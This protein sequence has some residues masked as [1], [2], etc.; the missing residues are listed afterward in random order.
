M[1]S[2]F[3]V[4]CSPG[5]LRKQHTKDVTRVTLCRFVRVTGVRTPGLRAA[6]ISLKTRKTFTFCMVLC[7][8][9]LKL[10][11]FSLL[12]SEKCVECVTRWMAL[13]GCRHSLWTQASC[14]S[15]REEPR[16]AFGASAV[17]FLCRGTY[18]QMR[19]SYISNSIPWVEDTSWIPSDQ[20]IL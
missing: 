18:F 2:V 16:T 4:C 10:S 9:L 13:W 19:G 14:L 8:N 12:F 7:E 3:V 17:G 5:P 15:P 1:C 20:E 11:F 6:T